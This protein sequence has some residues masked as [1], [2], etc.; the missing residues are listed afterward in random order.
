MN[1]PKPLHDRIHALEERVAYLEDVYRFTQDALEMAATLGDFHPGFNTFATPVSILEESRSRIKQLVNFETL[2]FYLVNEETAEFEMAL[3]EPSDRAAG[4]EREMDVMVEARTLAWALKRKRPLIVGGSVPGT[5]LLVNCIATA[6]RIRGLFLGVLSEDVCHIPDSS[7]S[8][9]TLVLLNT[10]NTLESFELYRYVREINKTL[11]QK[12]RQLVHSE[13]ALIVAKEA[14]ES[15]SHS[16]SQFL[17]NMSHEIRTPLHGM[18]GMMQLLDETELDLEQRDYVKTAVASGNSLLAIINDILDFSKIES[19]KMQLASVDFNLVSVIKTVTDSFAHQ[20]REKK[21]ALSFNVEER[22]PALLEGDE[23]RLR[24]ILFNLVGNA[25]KFT[26]AGHV[27]VAARLLASCLEQGCVDLVICVDDSGIG[28]PHDKLEYLFESFTQMDGSYS[29]KYQGTGLGLAIVKGLVELMGG[30][31][32]VETELGKGTSL[33]VRMRFR[34]SKISLVDLA[35]PADSAHYCQPGPLRVLLAEDN[36]ANRVVATQ[37]LAALGHQVT[38]ACN[39]REALSVLDD[40]LF[41][42]VLMDIQMP[43]MDGL[44]ATRHIRQR[45]S[46]TARLPIVAMTAY[47]LEGDR[48]RFLAAGMDAYIAKP[49]TPDE[50][51]R[52]LASA[53]NCREPAEG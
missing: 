4:I 43:E 2:C 45:P 23:G 44:E 1:D 24:Q 42:L 10:A 40:A 28:I 7:L 29:R 48:E 3:C 25:M 14:A 8:L 53:M 18:L 6:S 38:T 52:V 39:G 41:D 51:K 16:K 35:L 13:E 17:A 12:V 36:P 33:S 26:E 32:S 49:L 21:L 11:E 19:G 34:H 15:A 47:A 5:H 20:A 31:I 30:S 46:T 22:I 37:M 9:L 50:L 27:R